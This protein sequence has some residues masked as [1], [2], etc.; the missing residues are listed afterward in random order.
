MF[1]PADFHC[2]A[3]VRNFFKFYISQLLFS[4]SAGHVY[5]LVDLF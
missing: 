3:E 4:S 1:D 2:A 5:R